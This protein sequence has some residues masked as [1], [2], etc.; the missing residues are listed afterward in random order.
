M[1]KGLMLVVFFICTSLAVSAQGFY[2]DVGLGLGKAWTVIDGHNIV[3]ELKSNGAAGVNEVAVDLGLKAGYGPFGNIPLYVAGELGGIGHRI[4]DDLNYLQ[5]NSYIIGSGV[6][7]YPIPLIQLGLSLGYSFVANQTDIPYF[8]MYDSK[9][10]FAWNISAAVDL[11]R[12][13]HG[14]LIGLKYFYANNTLEVSNAHEKSS[15]IG[16]FV[17]YAYRKKAPSLFK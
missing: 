12:K 6:I 8:L 14:C 9:G 11:G 7:F 10:G 1:K 13:K 5:F 4:V 3:D 2:F 16:V 17:K 15:M